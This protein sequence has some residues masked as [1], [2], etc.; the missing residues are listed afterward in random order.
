M[1]W[2]VAEAKRRFS[3][4]LRAASDEPQLILN[5]DRVVAAVVDASLLDAFMAWRANGQR[6]TLADGSAALR[7]VCAEEGYTLELP[8]RKDRPNAFADALADPSV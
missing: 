3:E 2:R 5:R 1:R 6:A 4:V 7:T 8:P